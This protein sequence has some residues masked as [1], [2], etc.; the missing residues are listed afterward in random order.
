MDDQGGLSGSSLGKYNEGPLREFLGAEE[1][2]IG[3]SGAQNGD[4]ENIGGEVTN[5]NNEAQNGDSTFLNRE[6]GVPL[7]ELLNQEHTGIS[8]ASLINEV[9]REGTGDLDESK[10][11][12]RINIRFTM[13][14]SAKAAENIFPDNSNSF[15]DRDNVLTTRR[16]Y[17]SPV[18]RKALANYRANNQSFNLPNETGHKNQISSPINSTKADTINSNKEHTINSTKA[19][20]S[21]NVTMV[22]PSNTPVQ[23]ETDDVEPVRSGDIPYSRNRLS[24]SD[25]EH[26]KVKGTGQKVVGFEGQGQLDENSSIVSN[27][28]RADV[29]EFSSLEI[30]ENNQ[31]D[32]KVKE[33][34]D[35]SGHN[36]NDLENLN[37]TGLQLKKQTSWRDYG[38]YVRQFR[39]NLGKGGNKLEKGNSILTRVIVSNIDIEPDPYENEN[40]LVLEEPQSIEQN[41]ISSFTDD[42]SV[43]VDPSD[44]DL[45]EAKSPEISV[46]NVDD[47][48]PYERTMQKL[49]GGGSYV[50][51]LILPPGG[52]SGY[53]NENMQN[54]KYNTNVEKVLT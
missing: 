11:V 29:T 14:V 12:Q 31:T 28:N 10:F 6:N 21:L 24:R 18:G 25:L 9:L 2:S 50:P 49:L 13:K 47:S 41:I 51:S 37:V 48:N 39:N 3:S 4:L 46:E 43:Q 45:I 17:S 5:D 34:P 20:T 19:D 40:L 23:I 8:I 33:I 30:I 42:K 16:P 22:A 36:T 52:S 53:Q 7:G 35:S 15:N 38:Q 32:V 54:L 27:K 44:F 26:L 1:G